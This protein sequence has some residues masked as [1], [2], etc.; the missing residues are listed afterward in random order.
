[1]TDSSPKQLNQNPGPG[2]YDPNVPIE[3]ARRFTFAGRTKL[4]SNM[5]DTPGVGAYHIET[6]LSSSP[7]S[8]TGMKPLTN[9]KRVN[10]DLQPGPAQYDSDKFR[11]FLGHSTSAFSFRSRTK[12]TADKETRISPAQYNVDQLRDRGPAFSLKS[13]ITLPELKNS[14]P[15]PASIYPDY[16]LMKTKTIA[17]HIIKPLTVDVNKK[18]ALRDTPGPA[19]Y[20]VKPTRNNHGSTLGSR[21]SL[22]AQTF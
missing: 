6:A 15:G 17:D 9:K 21:Y 19:S 13:R 14:G 10:N 16:R 18:P 12:T 20:D 1:M 8:G 11:K 2:A 4:L 22:M 7:H 3:N 5:S